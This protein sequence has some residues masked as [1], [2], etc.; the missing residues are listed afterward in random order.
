MTDHEHK[1]LAALYSRTR[2]EQ[3]SQLL[4]R[5]ILNAAQRQAGRRQRRWIVGLSTAAV[6]VLSLSVVL[7]T[8]WQPNEVAPELIVQDEPKAP[9]A[10]AESPRRDR[11][12]K[13]A[14]QS[15]PPLKSSNILEES[16]RR[17]RKSMAREM[18]SIARF[19]AGPTDKPT[20]ADVAAQAD[21]LALAVV[22][23]LPTH[24][25]AL[26]G[27]AP[28]ALAVVSNSGAVEI[29]LDG[30]RVLGLTRDRSGAHFRAWR[31]SEIFGVRVD[32]LQDKDRLSNCHQEGDKVLCALGDRIDGLFD[33]RRLD[34]IRWTQGQ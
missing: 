13:P 16:E 32:W 20:P 30:V 2:D 19:D 18:D 10:P 3:P 9:P 26:L 4:D 11:P 1:A 14:A 29:W 22:P 6:L 27:M 15:A 33:G 17:S 12:P 5:R 23:E 34:H 21:R 7:Q 24:K 28:G 25:E 8:L 31:G